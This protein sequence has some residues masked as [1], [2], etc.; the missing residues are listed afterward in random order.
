VYARLAVD[1]LAVQRFDLDAL[2]LHVLYAVCCQHV[3]K[4]QEN[5]SF[6]VL[7]DLVVG[8]GRGFFEVFG[9][10]EVL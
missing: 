4:W 2:M 9:I 10:F 1:A 3:V 8:S 7:F 5:V 6:M